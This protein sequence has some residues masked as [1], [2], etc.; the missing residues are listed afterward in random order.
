MER[1]ILSAGR[2]A[3]SR[4]DCLRFRAGGVNARASQIYG[5]AFCLDM[6][7]K[8]ARRDGETEQRLYLLNAWRDSPLY[9]DRER[10]AL[11]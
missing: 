10:T 1:S 9:R 8:E 7:S 3:T 4:C 11:A 2:P 6:H 5:C